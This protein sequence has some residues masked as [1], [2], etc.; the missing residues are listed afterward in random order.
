MSNTDNL[1]LRLR[2]VKDNVDKCDCVAD[3]GCD[4]GYV[5]IALI[6]EKKAKK[7]IACDINEGPLKAASG[8]ISNAGFENSIETRLSDG[9]HNI[10]EAD[11]VD[12][13]II[14]GM[15][16]RLMKRILEEGASIVAGASQ[17]I[18]QPQSEMFLVRGWLRENGFRILKET[19]L[20]DMSKFYWVIKAV[21]G[22]E[23]TVEASLQKAYDEYSGYL[24]KA[25]DETLKKYLRIQLEN[26]RRYLEGIKN[27]QETTLPETIEEIE[28]V[29]GLME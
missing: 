26:Q 7:V 25:K 14:A 11:K 18:L 24:I 13:I 6:D 28:K 21:K 23:T 1:S 27:V 29:L 15:G 5:S 19:M 20:E 12:A 9:L 17:L 16:G 22:K 3:I 10:T 8:N 2:T 4:H